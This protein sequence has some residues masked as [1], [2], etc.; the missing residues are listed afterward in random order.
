MMKLSVSPC[1]EFDLFFVSG[2][3]KNLSERFPRSNKC[4]SVTDVLNN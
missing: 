2:C 4:G 3:Y 1:H